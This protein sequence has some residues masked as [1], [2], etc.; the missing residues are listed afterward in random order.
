MY[1]RNVLKKV[2]ICLIAAIG[3]SVGGVVGAILGERFNTS[4][5][6]KVNKNDVKQDNIISLIEDFNSYTSDNNIENI[7]FSKIKHFSVTDYVNISIYNFLHQSFCSLISMGNSKTSGTIKMSQ[8]ITTSFIKQDN[9]YFKERISY[10]STVKLANRFYNFDILNGNSR[11]I[12]EN[13][14]VFDGEVVDNYKAKYNKNCKKYS[15]EDYL[16]YFGVNLNNPISYIICNDALLNST[17]ID[18]KKYESSIVLK[19]NVYEVTIGLDASKSTVNYRKEILSTITTDQE[20]GKQVEPRF[21]SVL[22]KFYLD[23][24][25]DLI[26]YKTYETYWIKKFGWNEMKG[27]ARY[28]VQKDKDVLNIPNIETNID[29]KVL[30]EK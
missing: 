9:C 24:K 5:L 17:K 22:L 12:D 20:N 18:N 29:Y 19:D 3:L 7:D 4:S 23:R 14:Y 15:E 1:K 13:N 21:T 16:N 26:E 6:P 10:S 2:I 30:Y 27:E 11:V 8:D 28:I 25:L